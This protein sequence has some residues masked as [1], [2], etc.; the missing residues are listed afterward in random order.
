LCQPQFALAMDQGNEPPIASVNFATSAVFQPTA[1]AATPSFD[2]H[3]RPTPK[4]S[5]ASRGIL[6]ATASS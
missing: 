3:R 2:D 6:A 1:L 4:K 5:K